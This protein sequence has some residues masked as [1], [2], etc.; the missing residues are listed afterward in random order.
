[1]PLGINLSTNLRLADE[2]GVA[3]V[4]AALI[5]DHDIESVR[6][7]VDQLSFAFVAPLRA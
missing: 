2:N 7:E 1:M 3:R 6:E 4:M 5:A